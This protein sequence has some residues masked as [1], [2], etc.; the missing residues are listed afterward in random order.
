MK[1]TVKFAVATLAIA[2]LS[3][4]LPEPKFDELGDRFFDEQHK[5][6]RFS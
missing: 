6:D 2:L 4:E 3:L 1:G 5:R